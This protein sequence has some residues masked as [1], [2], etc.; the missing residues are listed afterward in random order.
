MHA[1]GHEVLALQHP[2]AGAP[3]DLQEGDQGVVLEASGAVMEPGI[4]KVELASRRAAHEQAGE[5]P[6]VV[7]RLHE[8]GLGRRQ[9]V[10]E[11]TCQRVPV[12]DFHRHLQ[13]LDVAGDPGDALLDRG[14]DATRADVLAAEGHRHDTGL[15]DQRGIEALQHHPVPLIAGVAVKAPAGGAQLAR[16]GAQHHRHPGELARHR[17]GDL[18]DIEVGRNVAADER[19]LDC[20]GR[21]GLLQLCG[22][23][24]QRGDA[25]LGRPAQLGEQLHVLS[26]Q[27]PCGPIWSSIGGVTRI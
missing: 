21:N 2:E 18:L 11:D 5:A 4:A 9:A 17:A 8:E 13:R 16:G 7:E 14:I 15:G 26:P 25:R 24:L 20:Q 6:G 10:E 22:T 23:A 12:V 19:R 1:L 27:A 3:G